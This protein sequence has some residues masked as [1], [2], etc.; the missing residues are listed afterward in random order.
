M[1]KFEKVIG[2]INEAKNVGMV[3]EYHDNYYTIINKIKNKFE[4]INNLLSMITNGKSENVSGDI[5]S[6]KAVISDINDMLLSI[7]PDACNDE[8]ISEINSLID[9]MKSTEKAVKNIKPVSRVIYLADCEN[10]ENS[11]KSNKSDAIGPDL[12]NLSKEEAEG[13]K[14]NDK[15]ISKIKKK[16]AYMNKLLGKLQNNTSDNVTIDFNNIVSVGKE[17]SNILAGID[18]TSCSEANIDELNDIGANAIDIVKKASE[19]F[20][21]YN[22]PQRKMAKSAPMQEDAAP[23]PVQQSTVAHTEGGGFNIGNFIKQNQSAKHTT[24]S[25]DDAQQQPKSTAFPHQI[26]GLT[27][28]QIVAEVSKHFKVSQALPAYALYD[29][30][31]NKFLSRKMKELDAKQRPNNPYLTQVNINEY[32]DVPE[33]LEKYPL[34]FT[35][36]CNDKKKIIVVLF[37]P[38]A[39]P[40]KNGVLNYPLHIFKATKTNNGSK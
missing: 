23:E 30:A 11:S 35:M 25:R 5:K 16:V 38:V 26:C 37:S 12:E 33:L 3:T 13:I 21:T 36:P 39:M 29:L 6:I 9:Q 19:A 15:I 31:N 10:G 40:D 27:D 8:E 18:P 22:K 28:E 1:A 24:P 17:V 2:L 7:V 14:V 34:C 20:L 4:Y 32:I